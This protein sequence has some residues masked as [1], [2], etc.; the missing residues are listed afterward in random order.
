MFDFGS[1]YPFQDLESN[2]VTKELS[3]KNVCD[4]Y[5]DLFQTSAHPE[6]LLLRD[7]LDAIGRRLKNVNVE[8]KERRER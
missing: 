2:F 7:K 5:G 8:L 1:R 4:M 6:A 3:F